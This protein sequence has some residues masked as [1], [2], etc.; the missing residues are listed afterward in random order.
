MASLDDPIPSRLRAALDEDDGNGLERVV[1]FGSRARGDARPESDHDLAAF[2]RNI[3]G[4][5]KEEPRIAAKGWA[6]LDE[7]S[8]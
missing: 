4:F 8:S 5:A 7:L 3:D 6:L 2:L 1:L